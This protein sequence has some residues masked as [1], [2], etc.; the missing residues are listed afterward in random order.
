MNST[1]I[2]VPGGD[3]RSHSDLHSSSSVGT[4]TETFKTMT[5]PNVTRSLSSGKKN[6]LFLF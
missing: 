2:M 4:S 3:R 1:P 5:P 6:L